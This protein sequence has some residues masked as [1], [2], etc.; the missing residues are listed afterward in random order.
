[1]LKCIPLWRCNR[2]VE[3]VDKRH[4]SL[5]TVPEEVYRYSRS[6]EELLLD[7]NQLRELPKA[8]Y[9]HS[10]KDFINLWMQSWHT[11]TPGIVEGQSAQGSQ[12]CSFVAFYRSWSKKKWA[13]V[14]YSF[15]V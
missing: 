5:Q 7:A 1:M 15:I 4:C 6:L 12:L 11:L 13:R 9:W 2:H 8:A 10:S 3:S 14:K